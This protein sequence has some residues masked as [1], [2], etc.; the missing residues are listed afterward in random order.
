MVSTSSFV[1]VYPYAKVLSEEHDVTVVGPLFGRKAP[2]VQDNKIKYE[3]IEPSVL[4]PVQVGMLSL[5]PKN[6]VRLMRADYDVVHAFQLLPW[7]APAAS[8]SKMVTRKKYILSI[9]EYLVG[10]QVN[11]VKKMFYRISELAVRNADFVTVCSKFEQDRYGGMVTYQTPNEELFMR[12]KYTGE[13]IR[14]KYKLDGK[15]V[16]LYAGTFHKHKGV[17]LLIEAVKRLRNPR[18]K[19][20]LVGGTLMNREV[21]EY[22]KLAGEET[23]FVG[24]VPQ[25]EIPE[26]VAACDIYAITTRG[27]PQGRAGTPAKVFEGML[28][29][30]AIISTELADI[31]KILEHGKAGMLVN[32]DSVESLTRGLEKLVADGSLRRRLGNRARKLYFDKYNFEKKAEQILEMYDEVGSK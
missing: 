10:S 13:G 18:V 31:P 19:L 26:F 20:L 6:L 32:P 23:I 17:D 2:Y 28:M 22:R 16:V 11:A 14:K 8:L 5:F 7:T 3:F 12:K 27:T 15:I 4:R 9:D 1:T 30:K 25:T 29:G 24:E 21:E